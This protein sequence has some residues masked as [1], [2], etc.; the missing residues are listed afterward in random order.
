MSL[1][2]PYYGAGLKV[3]LQITISVHLVTNEKTFKSTCS[4][5]SPWTVSHVQMEWDSVSEAVTTIII[6]IPVKPTLS[7]F[8]GDRSDIRLQPLH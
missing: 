3:T 4:V 2:H 7:K 8:D 6:T 1:I 5:V